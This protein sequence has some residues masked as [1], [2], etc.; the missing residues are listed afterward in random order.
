MVSN[1][2]KEKASP[3]KK[4]T[5]EE[6]CKMISDRATRA[7]EDRKAGASET[8]CNHLRMFAKDVKEFNGLIDVVRVLND[9]TAIEKYL[10][11]KQGR[12]GNSLAVN[13]LKSYYTSL[14]LG[15]EVAKA[16]QDA[17]DFYTKKMNEYAG[18]ANK[19]REENYIPAKFGDKMPP[20]S[21][22]ANIS[23]EFTGSTKYGENHLVTALYTMIP[24]RRLEYFTMIYLDKKPS[25]EP[26]IKPHKA[27]KNK[28]KDDNG[29]PWN[30][31]YPNGD[32]F[33]MVLGD[34]KTV[35]SYGLY[36]TTLPTN[37]SKIIR[38][39]VKKK[40]V[41]NEQY[42]IRTGELNPYVKEG[43]SKK[44]TRAF[45]IK[46][47]KHSLSVDTI[48]NIYITSLHNNEFEVNGKKYSQMTKREKKELS[49]S[50]GHSIDE[51]L[52]YARVQPKPKPTTAPDGAGTSNATPSVPEQQPNEP[53]T[54][55]QDACPICSDTAQEDNAQSDSVDDTQVAED[56]PQATNGSVSK[57]ELIA[58]MKKYYDL[59]IKV[60]QKKLDMLDKL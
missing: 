13:S 2:G 44:V 45:G 23:N 48:R 14:K 17:I 59:K 37:L 34:Y 51:S 19:E 7:G 49:L 30:Y 38:E 46:Y 12:G 42:L 27:K 8:A 25:K 60:L 29:N 1:K 39:Y 11:N 24:V 16:K 50:M 52:E 58:T 41:K 57:D 21:D 35:K 26:E 5:V 31:I 18:T 40:D 15:A 55:E 54:S 9:Y 28:H 6:L 20:W 22:I 4:L 36:Q 3:V 47:Q 56:L 53:S 32:A 10:T 33:E 43:A